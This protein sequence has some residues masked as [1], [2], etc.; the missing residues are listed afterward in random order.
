[1]TFAKRDVAGMPA[2]VARVSFSGELAYEINV[3]GDL[4]LA[5]WD[6]VL[7][8]GRRAARAHP[9]GTEAMHVLRAEKG[10]VIVGQDTDG[11]ATPHDLGMSW[12]VRRTTP[13]SSAGG[14]SSPGRHRARRPQAARRPAADRPGGLVARGRAARL[15]RARGD[16]IRRCR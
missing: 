14:R 12:I 8:A 7:A 3:E 10:F 13:T 5:M 11:T 2:R 6:A 9:Y 4:G 15:A 1:M 16:A